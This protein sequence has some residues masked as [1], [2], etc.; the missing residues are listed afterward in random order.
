MHTSVNENF[1]RFA[2]Y[3]FLTVIPAFAA[4]YRVPERVQV[5]EGTVKR[6]I[7]PGNE[8]FLRIRLL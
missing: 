6:R 4:L 8:T 7:F 3:I 5:I 2:G 1:P